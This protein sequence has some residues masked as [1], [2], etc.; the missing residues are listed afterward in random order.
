VLGLIVSIGKSRSGRLVLTRRWWRYVFPIVI[1]ASSAIVLIFDTAWFTRAPSA[2]TATFP[3]LVGLGVSQMFESEESARFKASDL[4]ERDAKTWRR[5]LWAF[6]FATVLFGSIGA[7][8]AA[9]GDLTAAALMLP[10]AVVSLL[11]A[12]AIWTLLRARTR[13]LKH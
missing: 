8:A 10:L 6:V 7:L 4:S 9:T 3:C 5:I 11:S 2:I 1:T 12:I 13:Q